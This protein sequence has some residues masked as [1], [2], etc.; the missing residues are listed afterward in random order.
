MKV[1]SRRLT[2]AFSFAAKSGSFSIVIASKGSSS[3]G[4]SSMC[5]ERACFCPQSSTEWLLA[6]LLSSPAAKCSTVLACGLPSI[7]DDG[8][9]AKR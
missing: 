8:A 7:A 9:A 4:L 3:D 5:S 1:I 2:R 6:T